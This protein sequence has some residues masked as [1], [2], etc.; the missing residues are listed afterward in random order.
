MHHCATF[1]IC[2]GADGWIGFVKKGYKTD[3]SAFSTRIVSLFKLVQ[4]CWVV[5]SYTFAV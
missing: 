5:S 1:T 2:L 3:M 4:V